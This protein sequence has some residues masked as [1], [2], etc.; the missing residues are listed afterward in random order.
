[1]AAAGTFVAIVAAMFAA[2]PGSRAADPRDRVFGYI[3]F[4]LSLLRH[5]ISHYTCLLGTVV[6]EVHDTHPVLRDACEAALAVHGVDLARDL[7]AAKAIYA[8]DADWTADGVA[9]FM[10]AVLQGAFIFAKA[11]QS[12]RPVRDCLGHLRH[13]LETLLGPPAL[14]APR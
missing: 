10:Q 4:R 12:P 5:E 14:K 2:T 3:D 8:P 7:A 11:Q 6:Q 9:L 1:M 13:Y